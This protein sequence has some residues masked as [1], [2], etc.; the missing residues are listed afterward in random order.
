[1]RLIGHLAT[2]LR[3]AISNLPLTLEDIRRALALPD[4]D[5]GAAWLRMAPRRANLKFPPMPEGGTPAAVLLML[6][7]GP[8][9]ALTFV[10]T[11]RAASLK[12]HSGQISLPGGM[13]EP[14][15]NSTL[16]TAL[17]EACEEI[18]VCMPP[19]DYLGE[20]TPMFVTVSGFKVHPHVIYTPVRPSF[21]PDPAEVDAVIEMPLAALID[22]GIKR[23]E[24][25]VLRGYELDVP[26]YAYAG[27]TIWGATAAML[28]EFELR[29]RLARGESPPML[30]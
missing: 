25:W 20:L 23:I 21:M 18:G 10:L 4:V 19:H 12:T 24:P 9:E 1:M 30:F 11:R 16:A 17:R 5:A 7:P 28:S 3:M 6:Y 13:Q 27:E 22:D 14:E 8:G 26:F 29:L 15:D 2:I